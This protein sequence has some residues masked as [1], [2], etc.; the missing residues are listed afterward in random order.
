[1]EAES[2]KIEES[3]DAGVL[4]ERIFNGI[5][6]YNFQDNEKFIEGWKKVRDVIPKQKL[7][8]SLVRAEVFFYSRE[9]SPVDLMGYQK[10]LSEN[11]KEIPNLEELLSADQTVYTDNASK[12]EKSQNELENKNTKIV[13]D[14]NKEIKCSNSEQTE[15]N[16]IAKHPANFIELIEMI[17]SGMKLPDTDDL[18][19]EPLNMDPTP[20]DIQSPKKPWEIS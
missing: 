3:A 15:E 2:L 16:V 20:C 11:S 7:Y 17:Q 9:V 14:I 5:F 12:E 6:D 19:I 4:E 8:E 13:N 10:W 18:N 1:M